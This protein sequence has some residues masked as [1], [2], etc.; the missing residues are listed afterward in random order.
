M[1]GGACSKFSPE[2][3]D[4]LVVRLWEKPDGMVQGLARVLVKDVDVPESTRRFG[5]CED[6][7]S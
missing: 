5:V 4:G 7:A 3:F 2:N 6:N 1:G